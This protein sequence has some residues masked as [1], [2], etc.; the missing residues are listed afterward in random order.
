MTLQFPAFPVHGVYWRAMVTAQGTSFYFL[1]MGI[2]M[3]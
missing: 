3:V 2:L 1:L